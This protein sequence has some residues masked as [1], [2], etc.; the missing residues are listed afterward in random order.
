MGESRNE[1]F[2]QNLYDCL[3]LCYNTAFEY[4]HL[5]V[6]TPKTISNFIETRI[7]MFLI[8]YENTGMYI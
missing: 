7:I 2:R 3:N 1:E 6:P 5:K 4:K 8:K